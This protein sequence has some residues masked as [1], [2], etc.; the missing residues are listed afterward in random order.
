VGMCSMYSKELLDHFEHPRNVGE[1]PDAD[2]RA[3]VENPACGDI[4]LLTLKLSEGR[5]A[6]ARFRTRGCVASIACG[7]FL[8]EWLRGRSLTEAR[9]LRRE[10]IVEGIGGLANE[11]M[12]A[13]HLAM[14]GLR[15][16]LAKV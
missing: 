14:D 13:S 16:A 7:S 9:A 4:M 3:E 10:Q 2:A 12:H 6:E 1:I 8:T 11:S 15:A 5:I